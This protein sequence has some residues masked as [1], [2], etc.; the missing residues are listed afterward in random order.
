MVSVP[1]MKAIVLKH[2]CLEMLLYG[3][4]VIFSTLTSGNEPV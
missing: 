4:V 3:K 1:Q 2:N